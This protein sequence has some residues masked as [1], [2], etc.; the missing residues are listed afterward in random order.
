MTEVSTMEGRPTMVDEQHGAVVAKFT[1]EDFSNPGLLEDTFQAL[2]A[3]LKR[4]KLV[5]NLSGIDDIKSLGV[6][7]LVAAQGL[8]LINKTELVFAAIAPGV[9]KLLKMVGADKVLTTFDTV[10]DAVNSVRGDLRS[11]WVTGPNKL[12]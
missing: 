3:G 7:V 9:M 10:D 8:A 11:F 2:V 5:V 6:A 1:A 12:P 4:R